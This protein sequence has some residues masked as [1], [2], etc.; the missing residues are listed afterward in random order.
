MARS[1]F[2]QTGQRSTG[3]S[4]PSARAPLMNAKSVK[5]LRMEL[6]CLSETGESRSIAQAG[7]ERS[8]K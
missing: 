5:Q 1:E 8:R 6:F 2:G 4:C 3:A 7:T